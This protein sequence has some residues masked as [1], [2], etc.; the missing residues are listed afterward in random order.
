MSPKLLSKYKKYSNKLTHV[1]KIAKCSYFEY[2]FQNA[3]NLTD[4]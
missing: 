2:L 3:K 4:T 1:K